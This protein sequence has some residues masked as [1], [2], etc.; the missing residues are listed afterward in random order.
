MPIIHL[1]I[2]EPQ[3]VAFHLSR[4]YTKLELVFSW[5]LSLNGISGSLGKP[6]SV[7]RRKEGNEGIIRSSWSVCKRDIF[8]LLRLLN[9]TFIIIIISENVHANTLTTKRQCFFMHQDK[10]IR[11]Q[12]ITL[13]YIS[14]PVC[15]LIQSS[16]VN[17]QA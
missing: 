4:Y 5:L 8:H 17:L 3:A 13:T 11:S 14:Q 16:D 7:P 1:H 9:L 10:M 15:N 6:V 12:E 2:N